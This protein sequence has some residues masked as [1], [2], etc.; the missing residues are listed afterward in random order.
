[1]YTEAIFEHLKCAHTVIKKTLDAG[2][3]EEALYLLEQ[4]QGYGICLGNQIEEAGLKEGR[5]TLNVIPLLENYCELVYQMYE[6]IRGF[7]NVDG[8][9]V[10]NC[11]SKELIQIEKMIKSQLK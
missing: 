1:M 10:H 9:A 8:N 5:S 4:C 7:Q 3:R 11:L 2:Q 6:E